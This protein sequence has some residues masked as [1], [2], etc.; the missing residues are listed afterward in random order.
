MKKHLLLFIS[1]LFIILHLNS[2]NPA[3]KFAR[4]TIEDLKMDRYEEDEQAEAVVIFDY[5]Q[6]TFEQSGN[7]FNIIFYH[8]ARVKILENSGV[9]YAEVEI[10]IYIEGNTPEKVTSIEGVTYNLENGQIARTELKSESTFEERM[11]ERWILKK[12]VM[13]NVKK[14]SIIEYSYKI[15]SPYIFNLHDWEFQWEIPVMHSEYQV[16]LVPFYKYTWLLQGANSFYSNDSKK[17]GGLAKRSFGIDYY[18]MIH[19]YVMKDIPAFR[20]EEFITS[21]NDYIIKMDWQLL[22]ITSTN[23][24]VK[25]VMTT[26]PELTK[27]LLKSDHFGGFINKASKK[28]FKL[29]DETVL[30]G[31]SE[32]EIFDEIMNYVKNNYSLNQWNSK[33]STKSL[34][35]FLNE[36]EGSTGDL[37]LFTIGLLQGA[38]LDAKAVILSTRSNGTIKYDYPYSHFFNYTLISVMIDG[39]EILA[40]ATNRFLSNDRIPTKCINDKGL[41]IDK[42][43]P[44]W[45]PLTSNMVSEIKTEFDIY[46]N[47]SISPTKLKMSFTE[48]DALK[49][50]EYAHD[51]T[52][53]LKDVLLKNEE[54]IDESTLEITNLDDPNKE[55]IISFAITNDEEL[56]TGKIYFSPFFNELISENPFKQKSR[57]YPID[58]VY[59]KKRS[60][61][62]K[63]HIPEA[64]DLDYVYDEFKNIDNDFFELTYKVTKQDRELEIELSYHFK[65]FIYP[66]NSYGRLKFYYDEIIKLGSKKVVIVKKQ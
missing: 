46:M 10:P 61:K 45:I 54:R 42:G 55:L 27:E 63:I 9:D 30:V 26:W 20:D 8:K 11:N 57:K 62:S 25:K 7:G 66:A 65:K 15:V 43:E 21:K 1:L 60:Y 22:S 23:G 19:N 16:S 38:R 52:K 48:N 32:R 41:V 44:R 6:S 24:S 29:I 50:R 35:E 39:E 36:K 12:F 37:N 18:E 17:A 49:F 5:G 14:G 56:N 53:K 51:K 34:N 64:Y 33:Y 28:T 59:S 2:Q 4:V 58:M 3:E 13:P 31:K 40:D 47:D